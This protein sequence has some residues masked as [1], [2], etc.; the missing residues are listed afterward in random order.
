MKAQ[1]TITPREL[2]KDTKDNIQYY[3]MMA[4][5]LILIFVFCYLPM[6]GIIIAF[7]NYS[8]GKPFFGPGV[9]WVGLKWFRQ[10]IE[11]YYFGRILRNK[12]YPVKWTREFSPTPGCRH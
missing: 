12:M 1:K 8:A 5:P 2:K 9:K 11:S 3:L 6:F 10:F 7:Q 4:L